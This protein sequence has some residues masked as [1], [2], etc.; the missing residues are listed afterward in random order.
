MKYKHSEIEKDI[1]NL[2]ESDRVDKY[3]LYSLLCS[4]ITENDE[5]ATKLARKVLDKDI[6]SILDKIQSLFQRTDANFKSV[7][8]RTDIDILIDW[9]LHINSDE[10]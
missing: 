9:L 8:D 4:T 10:F 6:K 1:Q 7:E 2:M 3:Y 5:T